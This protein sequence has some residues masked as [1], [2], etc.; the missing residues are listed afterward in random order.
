MLEKRWFQVS[1]WGALSVALITFILLRTSYPN[2][3]SFYALVWG[4]DIAHGHLPD[5]DVFRTPTP[6]PLFNA[7]TAVLS[8]TGSHAVRI[9]GVLSVAMYVSLLFGVYRMVRLKIGPVVAFVTVLVLLTR[10]DLLAFAYRSMLDIPF[11]NLIVWAAVLELK[12]P[13]RGTAPLVLLGL[14]GLLRPEAWILSAVYW[15][16]LAVGVVRPELVLPGDAPSRRRL[17]TLAAL[18]VGP[19]LL[20]LGLDW[21]VAGDPF[22]SFVSTRH[23]AGELARRKSLPSSIALI[24]R[25]L[26]N[27]EPVV[28]LTAGTLGLAL[29]VYALRSRMFMVMALAASGVITYL[30][31]ALGG[32]SVIERY[33]LLPSVV[34]CIGVAF[35]LIGWAQL[36][37]GARRVGIAVAV[38]TVGLIAIRVPAY[39]SEFDK[40]GTDTQQVSSRFGGISS[41]L[42]TEPV[43]ADAAQCRPVLSPTHEAVPVIRYRLGLGKRDVVATTQLHAAPTKGLQMLQT[44]YLD[45]VGLTNISHA[46]RKPWTV[47]PLPGFPYRAE[48]KA[49]IVYSRC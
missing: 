39:V 5:Y 37:G 4:R 29:A 47:F 17:A 19:P 12:R 43:A 22:Y 16:W 23:V 10:T 35:A 11:L 2:Y 32:L 30:L 42:A 40:F 34:G 26:G 1:F 31:I 21:I 33:L 20:W 27:N 48:N 46:Q 7:Y 44:G 45:P 18:V 25:Y 8:L 49:W 14:A 9:M 13:R 3:D 28:T 24:P 36:D 15:A 41:I 6:H 38:A